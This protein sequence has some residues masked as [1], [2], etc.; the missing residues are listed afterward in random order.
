MSASNDDIYNSNTITNAGWSFMDFLFGTLPGFTGFLLLLTLL[1]IFLLAPRFI[2]RR[3]FQLFWY[4]HHLFI[5]MYTIL[6][7]HA[8]YFWAWAL[9]SCTIYGTTISAFVAFLSD[10]SKMY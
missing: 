9:L 7:L 8:R 10:A 2:R 4:G 5:I 3:Y 6:L 1:P